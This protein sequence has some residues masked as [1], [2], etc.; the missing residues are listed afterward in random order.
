[1]WRMAGNTSEGGAISPSFLPDYETA[2]LL[3]LLQQDMLRPMWTTG[4]Q[5]PQW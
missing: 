2:A 4:R 3:S 1:M 5:S